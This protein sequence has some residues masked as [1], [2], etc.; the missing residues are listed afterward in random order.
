MSAP[1]IREHELRLTAATLATLFFVEQIC[2]SQL[3]ITLAA[4]TLLCLAW[5]AYE[6]RWRMRLRSR[7]GIARVARL[8]QIARTTRDNPASSRM[9]V[10]FVCAAAYILIGQAR[11]GMWGGVIGLVCGGVYVL[12]ALQAERYPTR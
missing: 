6:W 1:D 2:L 9:V 3:D 5:A 7:R 8:D 4:L 11:A 10:A 12:L